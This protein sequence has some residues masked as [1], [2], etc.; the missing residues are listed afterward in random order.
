MQL[1]WSLIAPFAQEGAKIG[2]V[3]GCIILEIL[4]NS[5]YHGALYLHF[6]LGPMNFIA[7][8]DDI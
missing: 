3:L 4:N 7:S 2:L 6:S 1:L 8:P 5:F